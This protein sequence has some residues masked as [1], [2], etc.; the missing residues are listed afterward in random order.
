MISIFLSYA[1]A[2]EDLRNLLEKHLSALRRQGVIDVWHDRRISP[3][4]DLNRVISQELECAD[5]IL[6][7]VS[8]DFLAS[9]YCHEI[10][11]KR[12]LERHSAGVARVIPVILRACDWHDAPFGNILATPKDGVPIRSWPDLDEAFLDVIQSIKRALKESAP[13]A[14]Q[15]A[16]TADPKSADPVDIAQRN[17]TEPRSSNLRL[18]KQFSE[19]DHDRFLDD[20]FSFMSKFFEN[21]V[22]ELTT[23][24]PEISAR[25]RQID[26]N[27]FTTV[28]YREGKAVA[29]CKIALGGMFGRGITYSSNDEASDNTC[30]ESLCVEHDDQSMY[31]KPMGFAIHLGQRDSHLTLKGAAEYYWTMFMH[32]LQ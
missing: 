11:M 13:K 12:A 19:A 27:H 18:R 31:L 4:A 8:A 20:A 26:S 17:P 21:S 10:E 15:A 25:F 30:N 14:N 28:V 24:H 2:D 5:I 23:R 1:H 22:T 9:D 3:G 32:P 7:L 29:R 6:L 16:R